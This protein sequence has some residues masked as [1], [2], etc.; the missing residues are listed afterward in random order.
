M[1]PA[2]AVTGKSLQQAEISST[3]TSV[4]QVEQPIYRRQHFKFISVIVGPG[5]GCK[6]NESRKKGVTKKILLVFIILLVSHRE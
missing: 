6:I 2:I 5:P 4:W 1:A 3:T